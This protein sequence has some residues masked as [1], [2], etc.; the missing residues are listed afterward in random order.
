MALIFGVGRGLSGYAA[1]IVHAD[2]I[3]A[4]EDDQA[5]DGNPGFTQF[6]IGVGFLPDMEKLRDLRLRQVFILPKGANA[7]ALMHAITSPRG[8]SRVYNSVDF[9]SNKL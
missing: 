7:F 5:V 6:V 3:E 4:G 1:D 2:V 9:K 8:Y